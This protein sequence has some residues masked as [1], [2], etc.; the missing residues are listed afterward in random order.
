MK[1]QVGQLLVEANIITSTTL[2]RALAMQ[3]DSGKRIG[4]ILGEMGVVTNAEMM[5]AVAKQFGMKM[6]KDFSSQSFLPELLSLIPEDLAISKHVFPLRQHGDTLAVAITDPYDLD[7]LD[8]L[9]QKTR[10]KILP[11][12]ATS[13]DIMTAIRKHYLRIQ[14]RSDKLRVLVIDDSQLI[15]MIVETA[16]LREGY[17]V[18]TACDGLQGVKMA[19]SCNPDLIISD[20]VM[21]QMDGYTLLR[22]LKADPLTSDIPIILLTAKTSPEDE[23]EALKS[24]FADFIAK[25]VVPVR[26]V[27]RVNRIFGIMGVRTK[28]QTEGSR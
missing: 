24:G 12:L 27:A 21:P 13:A 26:I 3:K 2:D 9:A 17:E 14:N 7:I 18:F 19:I 8:Y 22:T 23:H 1:K 6:V 4:V 20:E 10:L 28:W 5:G 25:P 11:V 15:L 16:L